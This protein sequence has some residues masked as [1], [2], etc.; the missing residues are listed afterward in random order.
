MTFL[1]VSEMSLNLRDYILDILHDDSDLRVEEI[2]DAINRKHRNVHVTLSADVIGKKL[3]MLSKFN[4]VSS[5]EDV[6]RIKVSFKGK[7]VERLYRF[8]R[9][10]LKDEVN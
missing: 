5:F 7:E 4:E 2:I 9:W 6:E 1:E 3:R 8:K 10:F